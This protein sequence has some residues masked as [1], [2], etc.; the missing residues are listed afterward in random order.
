MCSIK[1]NPISIAL[2]H[3]ALKTI[4]NGSTDQRSESN[5][6]KSNQLSVL[7]MV[8]YHVHITWL[9]SDSL[10]RR[11]R[12]WWWSYRWDLWWFGFVCV[13]FFCAQC[14]CFVGVFS[15]VLCRGWAWLPWVAGA[16][17]S[18]TSCSSSDH[19]R[20]HKNPGLLSTR[21]QIVPTCRNGICGNRA[22]AT[23]CDSFAIPG[24]CATLRSC[25]SANSLKSPKSSVS[26]S[27]VP[28]P[29][30][31]PPNTTSPS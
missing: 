16:S 12:G 6:T 18:H 20:Q 11:W 13:V 25:T 15:E 30:P 8:S 28:P 9:W 10:V 29:K 7:R 4:H 22:R 23:L 19:Q 1:L 3:S 2:F 5:C 26:H 31:Q 14:F 17:A 24:A 21:C 27:P